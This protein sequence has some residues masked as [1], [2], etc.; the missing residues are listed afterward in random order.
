MI[1]ADYIRIVYVDE[2]YRPVAAL[3][4]VDIFRIF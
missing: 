2:L 4:I 3:F 1:F